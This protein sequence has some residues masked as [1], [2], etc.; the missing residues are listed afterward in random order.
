MEVEVPASAS[1]IGTA[2]YLRAL[3]SRGRSQRKNNRGTGIGLA[4]VQELVKLHGGSISVKSEL[5]RAAARGFIHRK[6]ALAKEKVERRPA[7]PPIS[8]DHERSEAF[9]DKLCDGVLRRR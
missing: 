6:C 4:L 2:A 8:G 5:G 3:P 9:V 1:R 7:H